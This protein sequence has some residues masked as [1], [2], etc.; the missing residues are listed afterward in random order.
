MDHFDCPATE[1][2][3]DSRK[4]KPRWLLETLKEAKAAGAP[5]KAVRESRQP[6]RFSSYIALVTDII[7]TEPSSYE[8]AANQQV[9]REA[10]VEEYSSIIK[11][12]VWEIVPRPEGKSI[13]TSRWLYKI[14]HAADGNIEKYKARFVARGFSQIEGVDYEE[15]FAPV[16]RYTSIQSIISIVAEMGWSIHQMD[17]KTAFLNGII[18][19]EV[20]IEQPQGFEQRERETHVCRLKKALYGLKQAPCAWY[21]RIDT[22]LQE[23][24]FNKSDADPNL[25]YIVVGA[26]PIILVLYVDDL[27]ITRAERLIENCK[28]DLASEFE[29]K[30]IGLMHYFLGLEVW[31]EQGHIFLGQGKYTVNILSRFHMGDCRPMPT[32]MITNWKK[33]HASD[34]ELVDPTLYR[35]LIGSL[36]YLVNTRPN[37]CFAVNT[38]S[39]FMVEPRRVHWVAAKHVLR[40]LQGTV[41]YGLDYRQG[42]GV[43]LAGYTDSDW[44]GSASDRKSTSRCCFVLGSA[45]VSWF[46]QK[47]KSVA[48]SSS[49][50]EYMAASQASCEA[51]WLRKML[52]GLFG[53]ELRPTM[54]FCDN[55]SCIKLMENP[56]FHDRSKHIEIRYH[57]IRDCVQWGAV[58]LEY[59]STE[60]QVADILTKS[61][62]RGKHVYFRDKMGV[63]GNTF[64]GKR[65]C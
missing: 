46:S 13:V 45:I 58:K 11:N 15:T 38:L 5:S 55:Q 28:K 30:D 44:A 29:M 8:E 3:A 61:L 51:I 10:M 23:M 50:A 43:R 49:E 18:Q 6:E 31:Q 52:V 12:D 7:E 62:P 40:Y 20:Y 60:E 27:F 63:V 2:E 54:I 37:I 22:Y 21:S 64:L 24:G 32:P 26:D 9:W 1:A 41:D 14:K 47:Q 39:Q 56:V 17:V 36:M 35:Q 19:E 25:Y 53:Q 65:E 48:L 33:L 42:D 59:I 4:K 57:F 16:A 34:S